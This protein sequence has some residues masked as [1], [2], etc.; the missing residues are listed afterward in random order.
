MKHEKK[1]IHISVG[2]AFKSS[3]SKSV[4]S[5]ETQYSEIIMLIKNL[6]VIRQFLGQNE[7]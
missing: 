4:P 1:N 6:K 3:L 2:L 5:R 7:V